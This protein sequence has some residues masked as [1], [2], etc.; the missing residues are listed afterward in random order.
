MENKPIREEVAG[1]EKLT[2]ILESVNKLFMKYGLKSVTM[3]DIARELGISKKTLY[4]YFQD[5]NDMIIKVLRYNMEQ[6]Q[7]DLKCVY[8]THMNA[9]DES[10]EVFQMVTNDLQEINP[11]VFFD[12]KKYYPE[13]WKIYEDYEMNMIPAMVEQNL[14]KGI[15]EGLY[16][17]D[18][19]TRIVAMAYTYLIRNIFETDFFPNREFDFKTL[20]L[21]IF[22][23]H[24]HGIASPKGLDYLMEKLKKLNPG[25]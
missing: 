22:R 7:C 10:F 15:A 23:Y 5:K 16:R 11:T 19:H 25:L 9:I 24:I 4:V 1:D 13:A 12:L 18:V 17:P 21:H 2:Q 3:D 14:K 8:D 20:Y 6:H